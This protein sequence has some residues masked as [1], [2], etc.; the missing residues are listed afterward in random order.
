MNKTQTRSVGELRK[1]QLIE[2]TSYFN[3]L[4]TFL[5]IESDN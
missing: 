5:H 2:I 1:P 4:Y 3:N